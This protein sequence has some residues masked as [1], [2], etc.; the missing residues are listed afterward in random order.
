MN[1]Q[2]S[3]TPKEREFARSLVKS[4]EIKSALNTKIIFRVK[5]NHITLK[6]RQPKKLA[7]MRGAKVAASLDRLY[8]DGASAEKALHTKECE[9]T[10]KGRIESGLEPW[11][12]KKFMNKKST[13]ENRRRRN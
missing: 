10:N 7:Q 13:R 2:K 8:A 9:Q 3:Y 1:R 6:I 4:E 5:T 11:D 12:F